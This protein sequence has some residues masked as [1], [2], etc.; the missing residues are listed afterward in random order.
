MNNALSWFEIPVT[1]LN[2]ASEFYG[3]VMGQSLIKESMG[4]HDMAVFPYDRVQ[5]VG[6]A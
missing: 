5:G 3:H 6:V 2:R 4:P 1:D